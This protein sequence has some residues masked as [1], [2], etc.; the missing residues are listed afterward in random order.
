M[1]FDDRGMMDRLTQK[2]R[3]PLVAAHAGGIGTGLQPGLLGQ[4]EF[5]GGGDGFRQVLRAAPDVQLPDQFEQD[6]GVDLQGC[7]GFHSIFPSI[8][9]G[10]LMV[11]PGIRRKSRI[12]KKP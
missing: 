11:R 8:F 7:C 3:L 10:F 1:P 6:V 12:P 2:R 5:D 4:P 9:F